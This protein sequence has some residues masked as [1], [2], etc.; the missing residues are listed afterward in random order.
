[1]SDRNLSFI[2]STILKDIFFIANFY[3]AQQKLVVELDGKIHDYQHYY[4][5]QRDLV[6]KELGLTILLI[7]NEERKAIEK[8]KSKIIDYLE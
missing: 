7:K 4:D 6:L 2:D 5:Y 3:C 1:M 8:V